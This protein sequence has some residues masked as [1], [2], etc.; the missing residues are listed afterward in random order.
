MC[1]LKT[2]IELLNLSMHYYLHQP[3]GIWYGGDGSHGARER[4]M[5]S[6]VTL[7]QPSYLAIPTARLRCSHQTNSF[8]CSNKGLKVDSVE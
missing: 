8:L 6:V 7:P 2:T 5:G 3:Y 4:R 1:H